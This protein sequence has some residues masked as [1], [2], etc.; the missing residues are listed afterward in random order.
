M[1]AIEKTATTDVYGHEEDFLEILPDDFV[2]ILIRNDGIEGY[3]QQGW[4]MRA[5]V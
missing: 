5:D 4:K 3:F 1:F 2:V